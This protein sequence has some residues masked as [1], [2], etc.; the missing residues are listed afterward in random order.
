M[1]FL[2]S[3]LLRWPLCL[4]CRHVAD[5]TDFED[6][7]NNSGVDYYLV[8]NIIHFI[9]WNIS[10]FNFVDIVCIRAA[11][12]AQKP[13][14]ILIHTNIKKFSGKYSEVLKEWPDLYNIT[15]IVES[16]PPKSIFG[17]RFRGPFALSHGSDIERIRILMKYGGIYL[18]RDVYVVQNLNKYRKYEMV[19]GW[20][21]N[22]P[23]IGTMVY[24]AH[25]DARFLPLYIKT[26][27]GSYN[28]SVWYYNAGRKPVEDILL[29]RP[30][31]I[32][33]VKTKFGVNVE[34]T[35]YLY[36]TQNWSDWK[37]Q[38]TI[39]LCINHRNYMYPD[40]FK[41]Y[42]ILDE[43]TILTYNYTFR[44]MA[45]QAYFARD[46]LTNH[47]SNTTSISTT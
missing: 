11:Y 23:R 37:K 35:H 6:F 26:Y 13:D 25:K 36:N 2:S 8:P 10:A 15:E 9:R 45:M 22:W 29:K 16:Y 38:D 44:E 39:H 28:A 34:I 46:T 19:L 27:Q 40:N 3:I 24:L 43:N 1:P 41:R 33:R 18:D 17:Q 42:P 4:H 31:L 7:N 12:I 47:L 5:K 14:R 21:N 30:E 20:I 32:H